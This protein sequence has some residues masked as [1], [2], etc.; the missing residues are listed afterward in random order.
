MLGSKWGLAARAERLRHHHLNHQLRR[1]SDAAGHRRTMDE[2]QRLRLHT[3]Q[4]ADP[5]T[6][7]LHPGG[8]QG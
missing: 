3:G 8:A 7:A 1:G 2:P 5:Q 4:G 6:N